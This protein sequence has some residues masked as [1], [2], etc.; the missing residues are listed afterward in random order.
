MKPYKL[1]SIE[2]SSLNTFSSCVLFLGL[3]NLTPALAQT[4]VEA[5]PVEQ[6]AISATRSVPANVISLRQATIASQLNAMVMELP[7]LVGDKLEENQPIA[8]L[9]CADNQLN[10]A[11]S[12]A[13]L[14]GLNA[15]QDLAKKQ[16][17]RLSRL[18][19]SH[20]TSEELINQKQSEVEVISARINE[21]LIEIDKN[22]RQVDKC[23]I[24]APFAG[25]VSQVHSETGNY[26]SPGNP[27]VTLVDID[28]IELSVQISLADLSQINQSLDIGYEFNGETYSVS[29]RTV[30]RVIDFTTQ[31][32]HMR[33]TFTDALPLVGSSGR[34]QWSR[35]GLIMPA[36]LMVKRNNQHGVFVVENSNGGPAL[37]RF[38]AV[39]GAKQG[40][41]ARVDLEPGKLVITDGRFGLSDGD[42]IQ[43][44]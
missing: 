8:N 23:Q 36:S 25:V 27:I 2:F 5:E 41:S 43:V 16:L 13:Q 21:Q 1:L 28:N 22:Q 9:D 38:V 20:N 34:L 19:Q 12:R 29:L 24:I 15:N 14:I 40:Q 17:D 44:E 3:L 31:T 26:V 30:L 33:F 32:R 42:E 35:P 18:Q 11:Q 4:S 37:A 39:D 6:L 10:L 7:L